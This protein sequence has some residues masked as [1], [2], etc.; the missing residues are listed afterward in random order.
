MTGKKNKAMKINPENFKKDNQIDVMKF[1]RQ[2]VKEEYRPKFRRAFWKWD[3]NLY[4]L[5]ISE[6]PS[7]SEG[8]CWMMLDEAYGN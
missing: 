2:H 4:G 5:V 1:V 8:V 3:N 6:F 7:Y